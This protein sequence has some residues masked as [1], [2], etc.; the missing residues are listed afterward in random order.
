MRRS[1]VGS[2]GVQGAQPVVFRRMEAVT[3]AVCA[4]VWGG[5]VW[6]G[7]QAEA[8]CL[9]VIVCVVLLM[10]QLAPQHISFHGGVMHR[11]TVYAPCVMSPAHT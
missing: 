5:V 1:A 11:S 9:C 4:G 7:V 2:S 3:V 10:N 8:H 6:C